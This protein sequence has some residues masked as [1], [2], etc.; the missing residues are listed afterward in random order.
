MHFDIPACTNKVGSSSSGDQVFIGAIPA[1]SKCM[2]FKRWLVNISTGNCWILLLLLNDEK[3]AVGTS[4]SLSKMFGLVSF[5][6][7]QMS[8]HFAYGISWKSVIVNL[9]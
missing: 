2:P 3:G 5:V 4:C 7:T 1:P 6:R 9:Y 8:W